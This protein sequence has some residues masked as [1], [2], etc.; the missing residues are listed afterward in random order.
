MAEMEGSKCSCESKGSNAAWIALVGLGVTAAVAYYVYRRVQARG[1]N[2]TNLYDI[3]D[4]AAQTLDDRLG[5]K[6]ALY[7]VG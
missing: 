2:V 6:E 7:A 3:C 5:V 1:G 4:R